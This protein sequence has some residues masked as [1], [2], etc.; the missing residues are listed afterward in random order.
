DCTPNR[1]L[2]KFSWFSHGVLLALLNH[3]RCSTPRAAQPHALLNPACF[4]SH[5]QPTSIPGARTQLMQSAA[6]IKVGVFG[7]EGYA[8][9]DS[10]PFAELYDIPEAE[11]VLR[12]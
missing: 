10:V 5:A 3:A 7:F 2:Y 6:P 1:L 4:L 12:G 9:R 11:E 8:N